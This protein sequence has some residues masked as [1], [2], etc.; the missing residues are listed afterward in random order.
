MSFVTGE[1]FWGSYRGILVMCDQL[2]LFFVKREF[3]RDSWPEGFAWLVKN[4]DIRDFT[5]PFYVILGRK[6]SE[7]LE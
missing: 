5:T 7:L 1:V 6:F 2:I 4:L 3:L